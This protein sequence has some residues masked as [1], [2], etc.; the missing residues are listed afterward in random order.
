MG[1]TARRKPENDFHKAGE[2]IKDGELKKVT[3]KRKNIGWRW[4][5]ISGT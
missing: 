4:Q 1:R 2:N 5:V 3:L